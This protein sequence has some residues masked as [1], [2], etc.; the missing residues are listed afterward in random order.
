MNGARIERLNWL[1]DTSKKG[2][3][4]SSGLMVNYL[5]DLERIETNHESYSIT[6]K[7]ALSSSVKRLLKNRPTVKDFPKNLIN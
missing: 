6:G 1:G 4:Q 7:T 2:L 3:K 5:Y